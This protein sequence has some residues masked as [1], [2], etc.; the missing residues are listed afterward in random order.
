MIA[1]LHDHHN[2]Y[3]HDELELVNTVRLWLGVIH[4]DAHN[5]TWIEPTMNIVITIYMGVTDPPFA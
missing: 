3:K 4:V 5:R 1:Q 2:Y